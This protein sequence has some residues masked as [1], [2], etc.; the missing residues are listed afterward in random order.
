[1][2]VSV[3]VESEFYK[4]IR[5]TNLLNHDP[6]QLQSCLAESETGTLPLCLALK[7][8]KLAEEVEGTGHL[9]VEPLCRVLGDFVVNLETSTG[10]NHVCAFE[11]KSS[12]R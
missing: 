7:V 10:N 9:L 8:E 5:F 1:M 2:I 3:K 4:H 12:E 6:K 11:F